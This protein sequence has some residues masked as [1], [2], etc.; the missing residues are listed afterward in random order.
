M[1]VVLYL[2]RRAAWVYRM[3]YFKGCDSNFEIK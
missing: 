1:I 3:A 2:M